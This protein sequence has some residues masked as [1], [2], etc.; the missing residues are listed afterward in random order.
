LSGEKFRLPLARWLD[1]RYAS[2][3]I[4]GSRKGSQKMA[5]AFKRGGKGKGAWYA[6]WV[7]E[8]GKH[9]SKST[10]TTVSIIG[11]IPVLVSN[12]PAKYS[13]RLF[14]AWARILREAP[15]A[16]LLLKYSGL[17][18]ASLQNRVRG[19]LERRGIDLGRV[20]LEG[21]SPHNELLAAYNRVD[22]ALDTQPY[23]GGL[24]TCEALW[25][26]VPVITFPGKTFAGRHATSHLMNAGYPQ[27]VAEDLDGYVELAVQWA[28]RLDELAIIRCEMRDK[29]QQSPLCDAPQ[30]ARDFLELMSRLVA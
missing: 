15:R 9:R 24:T 29:V 2:S 4:F 30:F 20:V 17:D 11:L 21:W 13:S 8:N 25:M 26:G 7:D 23:S 27:F 18:Q 3:R 19:Q 14:D 6:S 1:S 10:G 5:S 22:L 12:N 16:Q 28:N